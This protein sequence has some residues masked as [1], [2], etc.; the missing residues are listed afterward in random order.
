[1]KKSFYLP[2]NKAIAVVWIFLT[3]APL[4]AQN[5]SGERQAATLEL[6]QYRRARDTS[7]PAEEERRRQ[8]EWLQSDLVRKAN[9]FALLWAQFTA[10]ANARHT[11]DINLAKKLE[12]AFNDLEKAQGWPG[13]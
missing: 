1:V 4:F 2:M 8:A 11:L 7:S 12:K 6:E 3:A 5:S 13:K 9:K 10:Q